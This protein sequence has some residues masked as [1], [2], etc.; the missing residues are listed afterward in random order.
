M[1][2]QSADFRFSL[3]R[4]YV[5]GAVVIWTVI[6]GGS[7]VSNIHLANEQALALARKEALANFDK[8]QGF[9][10]WGT[11]HGGVYVPV[12]EETPPSPYLSHIPE[13]D[14]E[15]PSGRKLTL[16]NPAY[17]VRQLMEDYTNYYGVRG[18]ITGLVLLRPENKPDDWET[19]AL[20][21][22]KAGVDEVSE[23][24][25]IDGAS[26]FR[27]MRPM[28][29][30]PGCEKCHGHLGFK[31]GDFRGGVGVAVPLAPYLDAE[32]DA[33]NA[34]AATHAAIWILG[35]AGLGVGVRQV[36]GRMS[37]R[38]RAEAEV[39]RSQDRLA[40]IL[41][42]A[43]EAVISIDGD[44]RIV[45]FN[46]GAERLFGYS[47][48][49]IMGRSI[50]ILLPENARACHGAHIRR[51][52]ES[53]DTS[54]LMSDRDDVT[55]LKKDGSEFPAEASISALDHQ[56]EK[57]LTVMI[58]DVSQRR[59]AEDQLRQSQ[60]MEVV[61]QLTGGIAHEFNNLL[62]VIVGN[63]EVATDSISDGAAR[64]SIASAMK[65]AMRA[66]ELTSQLLA[67]SRTKALK[68][69]YIDPNALVRETHLML[70]QT[71]GETVS[72]DIQ[73]AAGELAVFADKNL[74]E[75]A[76]LNLS[77]NA[78][79]AMPEGG[80]LTLS[81]GTQILDAAQLSH[82]PNVVAGNYVVL[83]VS[84]TGTGM[85]AKVLERVFD[86][87]FTTKD[88]GEGTGL[89][90]SMVH[91]FVEQSGGFIDIES[92]EG[93]GT[94][95]GIYL[96][97]AKGP[98]QIEV[99]ETVGTAPAVIIDKTILIVED[100]PNVRDLVVEQLTTV[101]CKSIVAEDGARALACLD[102]DHGI[103][104]LLTDVVLPGG[105]SGPDLAAEAVRRDPGIKVLFMSGY[106][107]DTETMQSQLDDG[108]L[109]LEKPYRKADFVRLLHQAL[110]TKGA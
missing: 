2:D 104:L 6:I 103:D 4:R 14:I 63:L 107:R 45:L 70:R 36:R 43:P 42:I 18:K 102:A 67:F 59:Q 7:L 108:A 110:E 81:T 33:V 50:D 66:A 95:V 78:R 90:L 24:S 22:L 38:D 15:T 64:K 11:K 16:L 46:K 69:E 5:V 26:Y 31:L 83:E 52:A 40:G 60:K 27:L 88:V 53:E 51:F 58:S 85:G 71:L 10:L 75:G 79:D 9:R 39:K 47:P 3:F 13:R 73:L 30:K 29:M 98:P 12:T 35:L 61:G 23:I 74:L 20:H 99:L 21:T 56:G 105:V 1:A 72:I 57:I 93:H 25:T 84:D 106:S 41:D 109:L 54:R 34:F 19:A 55:G 8:D 28:Y 32:R 44:H 65:G 48:G 92:E 76:L 94:K 62:T 49:E 87:F 96:P 17:M 89:G 82:H 91:G 101:G 97:S 37:E 86:P 100:D 80:A 68:A 77:L